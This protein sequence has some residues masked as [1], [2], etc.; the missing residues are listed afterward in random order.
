[1]SFLRYCI[2][3][4]LHFPVL[5]LHVLIDMKDNHILNQLPRETKHQHRDVI[6]PHSRELPSREEGQ[7]SY[8]G[9]SEE[10]RGPQVVLPL[11]RDTRTTTKV[12][13]RNNAAK[14]ASIE[15]G[16]R[17]RFTSLPLIKKSPHR[18]DRVHHQ[19]SNVHPMRQGLLSEE[20]MT[21]HVEVG[22][23]GKKSV[24][25]PELGSLKC[26][27][28]IVFQTVFLNRFRRVRL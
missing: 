4:F 16:T 27:A 23:P 14:T 25:F 11:S 8:E 22:V 7:L 2:L 20:S 10:S 28:A 15:Q 19:S 21:A 12:A 9:Q 1:V 26:L 5:P 17:D 3:S 6:L 24:L 18:G 13:T